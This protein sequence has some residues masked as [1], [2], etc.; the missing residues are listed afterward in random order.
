MVVGVGDVSYRMPIH[1]NFE[2]IVSSQFRQSLLDGMSLVFG[3]LFISF[4][5]AEGELGLRQSTINGLL[6]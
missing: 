4:Y 6:P 3:G 1:G 5:R 2:F